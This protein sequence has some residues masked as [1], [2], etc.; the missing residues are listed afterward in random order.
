VGNR[1]A[2]TAVSTRAAGTAVSTRAA[3]T[4]VSSLLVPLR[5]TGRAAPLYL[6]HG[7]HGQAFVTPGFLDAVPDEHPVFGI[8]ARGLRDGLQPHHSVAAM[9][10]EY[11][12]TI[13]ERGHSQP[14]ILV[15]ICAGG[16]IAIEMA[17]QAAAATGSYPPIVMLDPPFP[18][19]ARPLHV[20]ARDL[21]AFYVGL[22]TPSRGPARAVSNRIVRR[23]RSR[24]ERIGTPDLDHAT[25]HDQAAV[26]VALSVGIALRRHTPGTYDGPVRVIASE[27]RL[28]NATWR[29]DIWRRVLTGPI[30][31]I[32]AGESHLDTLDPS[33][34]AFRA[35]LRRAIGAIDEKRKPLG[36]SRST[37]SRRRRVP[38]SR[39]RLATDDRSIG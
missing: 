6:I 38:P 36:R 13:S 20:R 29:S 19:Y 17:R 25:L 32:G 3:S 7:W 39:E 34:V 37:T 28:E 16:V 5:S 2:G 8:Q 9:A 33:N 11:L 26:R 1:A 30:E 14:P 23:L 4:A 21:C 24:A 27:R 31:L 35:A 10:S 18:P 15:G 22:Y 12:A